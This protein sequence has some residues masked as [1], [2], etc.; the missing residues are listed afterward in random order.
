MIFEGVNDI[1]TT[2]NTTSAQNDIYNRLIVAYSQIISRVHT[3]GIPIFAATI[4]PF[5]APNST[6]QAYSDP[7]RENTRQKINNWIKTSG[8]FD[9]VVDFAAILEDPKN[10]SQLNPI[11]NSGDYLHPNVMGYSL[12]ASQ[13]PLGIFEQFAGGVNTFQ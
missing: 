4:T 2:P 5:S 7:I 3:F 6:I 9:A 1:G 11:Y 12:I 10:P 13:F 8:K